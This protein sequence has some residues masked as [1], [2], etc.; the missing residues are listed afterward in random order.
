[1]PRSFVF[2][3]VTLSPI[4]LIAAASVWGSWWCVAALIY[5][6]G[7]TFSL[8][9]WSAEWTDDA[10][11]ANKAWSKRLL[12]VLGVLH[13]PLLA[14]VVWALGSARLDVTE[15]TLLFLAAGQ[16]F[17]Q[18]SN[19][20][21]HE[22]IHSASRHLFGLGKWIYITLLFGHHTSAHRLIHHRYVGTPDD[23][24]T[25]RMDESF[26]SYFTR[27]WKDSFTRGLA[28]ENA[29]MVSGNKA[30][31]SHP[32]LT[33]CLG[34]AAA[35][36]IAFFIAGPWGVVAHLALSIYAQAQLLLS[37]YVQ[38]YGL[39]RNR[40]PDGRYE[41][42]A[43]HHSWNSPHWFSSTLLLNAPRHSDHH[44]HPSR[45][46]DQLEI[47]EDSPMLPRSLPAMATIA[48]IPSIWF[49]IMNPRVRAWID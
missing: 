3:L 32:Y 1:M 24:N 9:T 21:A 14:L 23:P 41:P 17:G 30:R 35:V 43:A 16:F 48:L 18:V 2:S 44:A 5:M 37:D 20:N 38:H 19:S 22:L 33:Y 4:A 31:T 27:A 7:L 15:W 34:G 40:L 45:R 13:F 6:T 26:Y 11:D 8:D 39:Y 49:R 28:A 25:S 12:V 36:A 42:V 10:R 47:C 46:F 29:R